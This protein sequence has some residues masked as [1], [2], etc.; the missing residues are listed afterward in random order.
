MKYRELGNTGLSVSEVSFGT[1]AIGG[2]WGNSKDEDGLRGLQ[3]A[4]EQGVNFFD[5]ADVYGG[6]HA[7][8]LLAKATRGSK[9]RSILP[10]S[11]AAPEISMTRRI[12]PRAGS[13]NTV[14]RA[15]GVWSGKRLI[16]IRS[17]VR[18]WRF[19]VMGV[20][21]RRWIN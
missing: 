12:I 21:S 1:W 4:M 14:S 10:R 11:S 16:C 8:E 20:C 2:D 13:A 17:T 18:R 19:C 9:M 5:T 15:C 6:G 3:A 7:E